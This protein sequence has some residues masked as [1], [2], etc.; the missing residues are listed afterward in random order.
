M[1][2]GNCVM[3]PMSRAHHVTDGLKI[4]LSHLQNTSFLTILSGWKNTRINITY[5][6]VISAINKGV[7]AKFE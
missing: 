1:N 6:N 4:Y 7:A 2:M 3:F 5:N